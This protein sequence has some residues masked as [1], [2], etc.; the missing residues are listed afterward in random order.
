MG[1]FDCLPLILKLDQARGTRKSHG[2]WIV[3]TKETLQKILN[4]NDEVLQNESLFFEKIIPHDEN[5]LYKIYNI[6]DTYI[7][8]TK[9]I[10][11]VVYTNL[12][13][14]GWHF[15]QMKNIKK[16]LYGLVDSETEETK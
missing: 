9:S 11:A 6:G 3:N 16:D 13:E 10:P 2:M 1:I 4:E 7:Q 14:D 12:T 8:Q 15:N 5:Q